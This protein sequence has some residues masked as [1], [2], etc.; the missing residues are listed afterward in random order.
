MLCYETKNYKDY[1]GCICDNKEFRIHTVS[2]IMYHIP[3]KWCFDHIWLVA[4][5]TNSE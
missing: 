2:F 3:Q 5:M 1:N 4:T